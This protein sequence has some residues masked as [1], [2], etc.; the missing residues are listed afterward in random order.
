MEPLAEIKESMKRI[1]LL[2]NRVASALERSNEL[3]E[4]Y[5]ALESQWRIEDLASEKEVIK[6]D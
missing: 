5:I 2:L 1:E 3:D 6:D 4:K